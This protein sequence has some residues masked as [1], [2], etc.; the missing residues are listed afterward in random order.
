M[1]D[2]LTKGLQARSM[3]AQSLSAAEHFLN[4]RVP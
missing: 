2:D 4:M 1:A 3:A